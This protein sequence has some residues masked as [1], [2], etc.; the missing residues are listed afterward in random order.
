M[1]NILQY[2]GGTI[3][4]S[5]SR[6]G[7]PINAEC[8]LLLMMPARGRYGGLSVSTRRSSAVRR[9]SSLVVVKDSGFRNVGLSGSGSSTTSGLHAKGFL[10]SK[11]SLTLCRIIFPKGY[12][13][14]SSITRG[15]SSSHRTPFVRVGQD[16]LMFVTIPLKR[17]SS[18][19]IKLAYVC[20]REQVATR[21]PT[22]WDRRPTLRM[23]R[24]FSL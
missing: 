19:K 24:F 23:A 11:R 18:G 16:P 13:G 8:S 12:R 20:S 5:V 21:S 6:I 1:V 9:R 2:L 4:L 3:D 17:W 15:R 10:F 14:C 7:R 22:T